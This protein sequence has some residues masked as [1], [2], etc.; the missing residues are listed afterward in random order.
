MFTRT[1][2]ICRKRALAEAYLSIG[3]GC[4]GGRHRSVY[5]AEQLKLHLAEKYKV[6][7]ELSHRELETLAKEIPLT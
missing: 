3:V 5:C 4:T 1:G 7:V 6:K 2:K